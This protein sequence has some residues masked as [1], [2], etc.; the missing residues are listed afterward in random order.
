[1]VRAERRAQRGAERV[2]AHERAERSV[3]LR[4]TS[5]ENAES[6]RGGRTRTRD[7]DREHGAPATG[8]ERHAGTAPMR[9]GCEWSLT[10]YKPVWDI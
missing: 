8:G 3:Q 5:A 10:S 2:P 7:E 4:G 1:M 9:Q 6:G